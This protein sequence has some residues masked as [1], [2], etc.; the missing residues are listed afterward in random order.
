M[1]AYQITRMGDT[2]MVLLETLNYTILANLALSLPIA[3]ISIWGYFR[4][5]KIT[6]LYFGAAYF[7]FS[8]SH[9]IQLFEIQGIF[10][11]AIIPMRV[12]GYFLVAG[13]LFGL[14]REIIERTKAE[15]AQRA[16]EEHLSA[17]FAQTAVGIAEFLPGGTICR[18]NHKFSEILHGEN[19]DWLK[20][21]IWDRL[22]PNDYKD[23]RS[24]FESVLLGTSTEYSCEMQVTRKDRSRIWCKVSLSAVRANDG[25][26]DNFTLVLDDISDLKHA[27]E[28]LFQLN[29]RLE[30]RVRER[31]LELQETNERLTR[32]IDQRREAEERLKTSLQEK[33]ILIKEI[34]HRVKNNLQVIIS[35]LYLQAQ[36]IRDPVL[37]GA[38]TDSQTRVKSMALVHEKLY[39]SH[40]VSSVDFQ[41][42]LENLV[43][44]LL[45]AYDIDRTRVRVTIAVK[46]LSL[47]LNPAISLGLMMNEL[48]SNALKYAFPDGRTGTLEITGTADEEMIRIRIRDNGRG[49]P[50]GFDWKNAKSLGLHLVQMLSRQLKGSVELSRD[51]GTEFAISIPARAGAGA[52]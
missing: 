50:E 35:L 6:P 12:C 20:E 34:H 22:T 26:P 23:H 24:G 2:T 27:E 44:N 17:A 3:I 48:I 11:A 51:G 10:Q 7:L 36:N 14:L 29:C 49:I 8:L 16:S 13:G 40:N 39:Q 31:T 32:E 45:I 5:G 30:E 15:A 38:L 42:Y 47:P 52:V 1:R 46:D 4:L 21:S 18:Y 25:R 43:A 37:A 41:A 9:G 19:T 33:E 28:E